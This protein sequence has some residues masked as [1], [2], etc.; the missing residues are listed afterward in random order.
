MRAVGNQTLAEQ[1]MNSGE[2]VISPD[3]KHTEPFDSQSMISD[4]S[5]PCPDGGSST[6]NAFAA[7]NIDVKMNEIKIKMMAE[8]Q[9]LNIDALREKCQ[10]L[11]IEYLRM[12]TILREKSKA[13]LKALC[14]MYTI[15]KLIGT[16]KEHMIY[17]IL[18]HHTTNLTFRLPE[19]V[20]EQHAVPLLAQTLSS[21]APSALSVVEQLEKQKQEIELKLKEEMRRR[22]EEAE[23]KA[24]AKIREEERKKLEDEKREQKKKKSSIPKNVRTIIW[25]HYIGED[26]IKHKC[27]CCKKVT[28][29]NTNF[30]VG[31]V[32][33]EKNGGTLE[34]NNL[35]PICFACNHSMGTENMV[36]FVVKFGLF[37]G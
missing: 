26:I 6:E 36:D 17:H 22:E 37:I 19:I 23:Q 34:I 20:D 33:S 2:S 14:K 11:E 16:K 21:D 5:E 7:E 32:L 31:H 3:Q 25:N 24:A 27:L 13:D 30:E 9:R 28:I 10:Q 18:H 12:Q 35:R 15:K 1:Y 29:S 8:L 4:L